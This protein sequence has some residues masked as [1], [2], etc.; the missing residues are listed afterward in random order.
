M[1]LVL[2]SLVVTEMIGNFENMQELDLISGSFV[3]RLE[4][5]KE[6]DYR[7]VLHSLFSFIVLLFFETSVF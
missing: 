3:V 4:E 6:P 2:N 5:M 1:L 7:I